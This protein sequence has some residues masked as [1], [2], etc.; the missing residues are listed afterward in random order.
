MSFTSEKIYDAAAEYGKIRSIVVGVI[1][2]II[3]L[4]AISI[5]IYLIKQ[6]DNHD[7]EVI[8]NVLESTCNKITRTDSKNNTITE[9]EC[10]VEVLYKVNDKEYKKNLIVRK[11]NRVVK[12]SNLELEYVSSNPEDV[13][14]KQIKSKY[15]GSGSIVVAVLVICI[16][17]LIVFFTQKSKTFSAA[18]GAL[19]FAS[20]TSSVVK[21]IFR[22]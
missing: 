19:G 22:N 21:N 10:S 18:T 13:R 5:G 17:W 7:S 6:K 16:L 14:I 11:P 20:D 12:N 4:I 8:G 15:L 2:T 9:F 3:G 1:G